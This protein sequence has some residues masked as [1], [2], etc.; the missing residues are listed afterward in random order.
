MVSRQFKIRLQLKEII[1]V[2][3]LMIFLVYCE[4]ND[5]TN[6]TKIS[7]RLGWQINANSIG[8]IIAKEKG[9]YKSVG[10][11]VSISPGGLDHPSVQSVSSG[12][13][14]IGF[15]NAPDLVIKA[16]N[17]GAPLKIVSVIQQKGYHGFLVK[18]KS[19]IFAPKDWIGKKVGIKYASPTFILYKI[20]LRKFNINREEIIEVPLQYGLQSFIKDE[21]D[22]Y[23]GAFT[24]EAISLEIKGIDVREIHPSDYGIETCGNV[25]FTTDKMIAERPEIIDRFIRATLLGWEWSLKNENLGEAIDILSKYNSQIDKTKE[26]AALKINQELFYYNLYDKNNAGNINS[27][28]FNSIL[29]Y[30]K[31]FDEISNKISIN[32]IVVTKF[33]NEKIH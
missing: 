17:A 20:L 5:K 18:E 25:I 27:D 32:E 3:F 16:I 8:Q 28:K 14:D 9:F 13:D 7:V 10:L 2:L 19:D 21:I 22:V 4:N 29:D 6:L 23:P 15:A 30:M 24:N 26:L 12:V 1:I 33:T 11:D 31:E